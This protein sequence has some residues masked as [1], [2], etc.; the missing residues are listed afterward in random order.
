VFGSPI[1]EHTSSVL[2][3]ITD[4]PLTWKC[5]I[6]SKEVKSDDL[7]G[8]GL[9]HNGQSIWRCLVTNYTPNVYCR[10]K[11]KRR[12]MTDL[13]LYLRANVWLEL[14]RKIC[15]ELQLASSCLCVCPS[16][17]PSVHMGRLVSNYTDF[18]WSFRKSVGRVNPLTPNDTYRGSYRTANL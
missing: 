3:I 11:S 6:K 9:A 16:V 14:F 8:H 12:V 2:Q 15:E 10:L 17:L 5:V 18:T 4:G 13:R 1:E 7:G